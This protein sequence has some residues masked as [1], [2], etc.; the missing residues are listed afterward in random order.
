M[1]LATLG[2][3]DEAKLAAD[4]TARLAATF[5]SP[6]LSLH[7]NFM[8]GYAYTVIGEETTR[9][10]SALEVSAALATAFGN[11]FFATA[12]LGMIA[13]SIDINGVTAAEQLRAA[14]ELL[15]SLPQREVARDQ[16]ELVSSVLRHGGRHRG[17]ATIY[18]AAVLHDQVDFGQIQDN[19]LL[20]EAALGEETFAE[21]ARQGRALTIDEALALAIDELD[22]IIA[23]DPGV[24][25]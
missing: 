18:G 1:A 12:A 22:A 15:R 3:H 4:E 10:L 2:R 13:A 21:L 23:A 25:E 14:L 7:A 11:P 5:D 9:A 16:L 20:L 8:V 6:L 19:R 17:A 24:L